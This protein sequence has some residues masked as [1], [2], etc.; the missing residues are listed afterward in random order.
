M[1]YSF[2]ETNLLCIFTLRNK[3]LSYISIIDFYY[4][5]VLVHSFDK[6][7][8]ETVRLTEIFYD[9]P[10]KIDIYIYIVLWIMLT[11]SLRF[12]KNI[13]SNC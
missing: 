11:Q 9:G 5:L 1:T 10:K 7:T 8:I 12:K 3:G 2:V 4:S 6:I 13:M